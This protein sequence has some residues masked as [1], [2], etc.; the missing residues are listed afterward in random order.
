MGKRIRLG[1]V[2]PNLRDQCSLYRLMGPFQKLLKQNDNLELVYVDEEAWQ[3]GWW[4]EFIGIDALFMQR[5]YSDLHLKIASLA[6]LQNVPL[7]LDYDDYLFHVPW[8]NGESHR[9]N[10]KASQETISCILQMATIVS[11]S[12]EE[13]A[14]AYE[15]H[16]RKICVIPNAIDPDMYPYAKEHKDRNRNLITWRGSPTHSE[17]LLT[18]GNALAQVS[19]RK[20]NLRFKFYGFMP[21]FW[22][23]AIGNQVDYN[24]LPHLNYMMS[25]YTDAAGVHIAPLKD[26]VFRRSKSNIAWLEATIAGC[27]VIASDLPEWQKP[28]IITCTGEKQWRQEIDALCGDHVQQQLNWK[29]SLTYIMENLTT[30]ITNRD[31]VAILEALTKKVLS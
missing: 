24:S 9:Y 5:P 7:W 6:S 27:P 17:D 2:S 22:L 18:M 13:I 28:G 30:D 21:W 16:A 29:E 8:D 31:R 3:K 15:G 26:D 11:V 12:T 20:T 25:L 14:K 4:V 1:V 19:E 10:T 23:D